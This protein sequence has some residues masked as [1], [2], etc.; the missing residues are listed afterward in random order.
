MMRHLFVSFR[1]FALLLLIALMG[2]WIG[3]PLNA[4]ASSVS[5]SCAA[6]TNEFPVAFN[7]NSIWNKPIAADVRI[8]P[9]SSQMIDYLLARFSDPE[10]V[11]VEL[12][13]LAWPWSIPI[14]QANATSPRARVCSTDH[15]TACTDDVPIPDNALPSPDSDQKIVVIDCSANPPRAWSFWRLTQPD[16]LHTDWTV[17]HGAYGWADLSSNG[18]GLQNHDGGQWGGR[19]SSWNYYAGLI[20]PEEIAQ[21]HIDHALALNLPAEAVSE[22]AIW[23]ARSSD[24]WSSDRYAIP[25]GSH[26]QLDPALDINALPLSPGAKIIARAL[27][28]YGAWVGDTG[29][30]I[31]FDVEEFI[32]RDSLDNLYVNSNPWRGLLTYAALY[33]FPVNHLRVLETERSAYYEETP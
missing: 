18:D 9:D 25:M 4:R 3:D 28:V 8:N 24:G 23:P 20:F 26:V 7:A 2:C 19:A 5:P 13:G 31:G 16:G 12:D 1:L 29:T 15:E 11:E 10:N 32:A 14:Y 21:G 22:T 33:P 30:T 27:Q 6:T 17:P